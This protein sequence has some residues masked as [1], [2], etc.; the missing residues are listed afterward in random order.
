MTAETISF[1]TSKAILINYMETKIG[2]K[3][4]AKLKFNIT[5]ITRGHRTQQEH[6]LSHPAQSH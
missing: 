5:T 2:Q 4:R 6:P 3:R 1:R